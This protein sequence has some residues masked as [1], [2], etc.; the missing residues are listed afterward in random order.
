MDIQEFKKGSKRYQRLNSVTANSIVFMMNDVDL[1]VVFTYL[2]VKQKTLIF[3]NRKSAVVFGNFFL[4]LMVYPNRWFPQL[5]GAPSSLKGVNPT[6]VVGRKEKTSFYLQKVND[7]G[8]RLTPAA[9]NK[10]FDYG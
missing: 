8:W 3:D 7:V 4:L 2:E 5:F 10:S 9:S 1:L 6:I